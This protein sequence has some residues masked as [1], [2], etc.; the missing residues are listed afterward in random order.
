MGVKTGRGQMGGI[1]DALYALWMLEEAGETTE[2]EN[3]KQ[4]DGAQYRWT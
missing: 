2:R 4:A 1:R 3:V